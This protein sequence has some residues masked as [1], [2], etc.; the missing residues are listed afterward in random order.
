MF[1]KNELS[2]RIKNNYLLKIQNLVLLSENKTS[3]NII[4]FNKNEDELI[5][6]N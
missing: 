4:Y 6:S 3:C 1:F 5:N 2:N